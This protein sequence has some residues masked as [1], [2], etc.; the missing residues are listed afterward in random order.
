MS[1]SRP[2]RRMALRFDPDYAGRPGYRPDFL[3]GF[4]VPLPGVTPQRAADLVL[5]ADG[6]PL[7]LQYHHFSLLVHA[8]RRSQLWSAVNVDYTPQRRFGNPDRQTLG[9]DEWRSD[10]RLPPEAL[11]RDA[12][13]YADTLFDRG[14]V[15]R[16]NDNA[17][18]ETLT[19][20]EYANADTFHWTNATP[21]HA[22]FNQS[23]AGGLWG[24]LEDQLVGALGAAGA[25]ACLYAGPVLAG[26]DPSGDFGAGP[27]QYPLKFWKVVVVA[28]GETLRSYAFLLDQSAAIARRGLRDEAL[29]E[30]DL[31][32]G[33]FEVYQV[34]LE[35]ISGLT[36]VTF[37]PGVGA[38]QVDR[39]EVGTL[40]TLPVR[41][42]LESFGDVRLR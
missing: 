11:L 31:N 40:E 25:R 38:A 9:R 29:A 23:R 2:V 14:H 5:G 16:R 17:W 30:E 7:E 24:G 34:G 3:P 20:L 15:V 39:G 4:T 42:R 27:V 12:D 13:I 37:A 35:E 6:A 32:F 10:P 33:G 26:S 28:E 36:G 21:Q 41:R 8:A 22:D 19:E 18:G 1:D